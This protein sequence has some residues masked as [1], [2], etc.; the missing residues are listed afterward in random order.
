MR[1]LASAALLYAG[2]NSA[3]AYDVKVDNIYYNLID[4][5]YLEVTSSSDYSDV[6]LGDYL[7]APAL[8]ATGAKTATES[9]NDYRGNII[10][11]EKVQLPGQ[12]NFLPV[13]AIGRMAFY[14]ASELKSITLPSTIEQIGYGAF[15]ACGVASLDLGRLASVSAIPDAMCYDCVDLSNIILPGSLKTIGTNAFANSGISEISMPSSL[16][17]IS[18]QAFIHSN[19]HKI[20]FNGSRTATSFYTFAYTP[21]DEVV[22]WECFTRIGSM[23][24][25]NTNITEIILGKELT[26]I[27]WSA[28][29]GLEHLKKVVSHIYDPITFE[30]DNEPCRILFSN[31]D[32]NCTLWVPDEWLEQYRTSEFWTD[33]FTDIRPLSQVGIKVTNVAEEIDSQLVDINGRLTTNPIKGRVYINAKGQKHIY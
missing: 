2:F 19:L 10:I 20:T 6:F 25:C 15:A 33:F 18:E 23:S 7:D 8:G 22:G 5:S 13:K 31:S 12:S 14:S 3:L 27:D 24:F 28:F 4:D 17:F 26:I 11:P 1:L 29:D 16:E 21:L 30:S 9:T 32:S